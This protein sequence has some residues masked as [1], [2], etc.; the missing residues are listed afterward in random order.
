MASFACLPDFTKG[1]FENYH[2]VLYGSLDI[3][4]G[5]GGVKATEKLFALLSQEDPLSDTRA[6]FVLMLGDEL[7]HQLG[8]GS[9]DLLLPLAEE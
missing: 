4:A 2:R 3:I 5:K 1:S 8:R 9:I 7:V 6:A